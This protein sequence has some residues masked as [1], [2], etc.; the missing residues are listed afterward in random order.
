MVKDEDILTDK[1][2]A[3]KLFREIHDDIVKKM[4]KDGDKEYGYVVWKQ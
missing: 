2:Y 1:N 4:F 3:K